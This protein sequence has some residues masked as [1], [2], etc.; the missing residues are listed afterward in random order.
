MRTDPPF[1]I[2][3]PF[4][5]PREVKPVSNIKAVGDREAERDNGE[6]GR[7]KEGKKENKPLTPD[8]FGERLK[9]L[10]SLPK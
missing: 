2:D 1:N 4:P 10:I 9:R 8:S 3:N 6:G 5:N 7:K